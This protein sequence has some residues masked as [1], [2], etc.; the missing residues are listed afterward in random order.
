VIFYLASAE[1]T[2]CVLGPCV[3]INLAS[4]GIHKLGEESRDIAKEQLQ[5]HK[6]QAKERLSEKE[7]KIHQLFRLSSSNDATYEW[8]KDQVED[9]V[10]GTCL[11]LLQH[12][13]CEKWLKQ[14]ESGPLLITADPGCGKSVLAKYLIDHG[15]PQSATCTTS[16]CYFFFKDQDQNTCRQAL[17]AL[18]HQLFSQKPALIAKHAMPQY[19]KNGKTLIKATNILWEILQSVL[20]DPEAG[21]I[22]LVLD[23]LDECDE[24]ELTS[25][26]RYLESLFHRHQSSKL[27][28]LLTCRP[29]QQIIS[30]FYS[31]LKSFP[32]IHIPGE[33]ESEAISKEV[34]SVIQHRI[35]QLPLSP[36]IKNCLGEKLREIPHRT[37]LWVH[38]IFDHIQRG[39]F[40]QTLKGAELLIQKLPR[41]IN[42][43]YERILNRCKEEQEPVVRK[44]LGIILAA[45]RPLTLSEMNVAMSIDD[46][47]TED[48]AKALDSLDLEDEGDFKSRL[49]S[50]C[51]LFISIHQGRV[52]F[53]HQTAREFL[54]ADSASPTLLGRQWHHSMTNRQAHHVLAKLCIRYLDFLDSE[55]DLA[56]EENGLNFNTP[57]FD[58]TINW[59]D[60]HFREAQITDDDYIIPAALRICSPKLS[61]YILFRQSDDFVRIPNPQ[62]NATDLMIASFFGLHAIAKLLIDNSASIEAEDGSGQTPL[63]WAVTG[64]HESVV[65]LL[66]ENGARFE[67]EEIHSNTTPLLVAAGYG[68]TAVMKIL[69]EN[70]ADIDVKA[71]YSDQTPLLSAAKVGHEAAVKL[72]VE[73]G[74]YIEAKDRFTGQTPLSNAAERGHEAMVRLLVEKGADIDAKGNKGHTALSRAVEGG[75]EATA[76]LLIEKGADI[77]ARDEYGRTPL[78]MAVVEKHEAI[79]KLLVK[80]GAN[81]RAK[82]NDGQTPLSIAKKKRSKT[83]Y[84]L[85]RGKRAAVSTGH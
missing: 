35:N 55:V 65:K 10:Q 41:N 53:L 70:G 52:Y 6:D 72:L 75:H 40:K 22:I 48:A 69:I 16:I 64:G 24:L 66:I 83:I 62:N 58:Y 80:E 37:Y 5:I 3:F 81:I 79:V 31:L 2:T 19:D 56:A 49:R 57:F 13:H 51:G 63:Y 7:H 25:L 54:L 50:W 47:A 20:N 38:L 17:C 21:S 73:K 43:A 45:R 30:K 71:E 74:A 36:K 39:D 84:Q 85:I 77:E 60:D 14:D 76:R 9:R 42:D 59:W 33:E 26:I 1:I 29:Y 61:S 11:W 12:N 27:K 15:L 67:T 18:L 23:A 44:A 68:D 32:N 46:T 82:D 34:D 4:V 28:V 78:S 8:Y